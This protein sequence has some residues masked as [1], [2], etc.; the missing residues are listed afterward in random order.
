[1]AQIDAKNL[2]KNVSEISAYMVGSSLVSLAMIEILSYLL[3]PV[4]MPFEGKIILAGM[5]GGVMGITSYTVI[6]TWRPVII[7]SEPH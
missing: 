2:L 1:M 3:P 4:P 5:M 7:H 6:S